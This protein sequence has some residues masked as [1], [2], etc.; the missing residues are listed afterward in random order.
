MSRS[1]LSTPHGF[2]TTFPFLFFC[3]V[4]Y[5]WHE[6]FWLLTKVCYVLSGSCAYSYV[7]DWELNRKQES[8]DLLKVCG[9]FVQLCV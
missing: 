3:S 9:S 8:T 4:S 1:T 6:A 7:M 5:I 2:T